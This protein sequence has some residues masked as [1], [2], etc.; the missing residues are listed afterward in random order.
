MRHLHSGRLP[1]LRGEYVG[2]LGPR[3]L[4]SV[5]RLPVTFLEHMTYMANFKRKK[6]KHWAGFGRGYCKRRLVGNERERFKRQPRR[7]NTRLRAQ[8]RLQMESLE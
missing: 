7:A 2:F 3:K 5:V 4:G 6:I 8:L 1:Y